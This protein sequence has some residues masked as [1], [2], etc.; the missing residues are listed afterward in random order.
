VSEEQNGNGKSRL[1]RLERVMELLLDDHLKFSDEH[2]KLLQSQVLLNGSMLELA[3]A[4]KR[5]DERMQEL[6]DSQKRT[7]ERMQELAD[8]QKHTDER[9]GILIHM[10]DEFIRGRGNRP[11]S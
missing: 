9:M 3:A 5:T 8:S 7:D 11:A 2:N 10:M 6:A 4:Q 1:D